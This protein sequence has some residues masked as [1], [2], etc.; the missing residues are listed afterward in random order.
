MEVTIGFTRTVYDREAV[1]G[2]TA[3]APAD[4]GGVVYENTDEA[5]RTTNDDGTVTFVVD[6][7]RN[8]KSNKYQDVIDVVTFTVEADNDADGTVNTMGSTSFNWVEDAR[9]YEQTDISATDYVL[10]EGANTD[11]HD[12]NISVSARL[13]D[14][15]GAGI[16]VDGNGNAYQITLTLASAGHMTDADPDLRLPGNQCCRC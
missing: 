1:E 9:T 11:N 7:P 8:I 15:Y 10:V 13:L 12:V 14:Q 5:T 16:R 6:A 3:A 4:D 2:D